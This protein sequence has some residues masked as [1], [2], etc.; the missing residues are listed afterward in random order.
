[1]RQ[2]VIRSGWLVPLLL[3]VCAAGTIDAQNPRK[4]LG[5]ECDLSGWRQVLALGLETDQES[6]KRLA[7]LRDGARCPDLRKLAEVLMKDRWLSSEG[8]GK[9]ELVRFSNPDLSRLHPG[10]KILARILILNVVIDVD[11]QVTDVQIQ[12]PGEKWID[13][14]CV[15]AVKSRLYRPARKA[16]SYVAS[17]QTLTVRIE[18]R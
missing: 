1:M 17:R 5:N 4:P 16:G 10:H 18:V 11:G 6:A 7:K 12:N 2:G 13:S 14:L 3:A 9:P 8:L 15:E